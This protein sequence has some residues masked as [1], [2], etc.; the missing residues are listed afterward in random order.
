M[1]MPGYTRW[2]AD[3]EV[4]NGAQS[5]AGGLRG[6]QAAAITRN[7][8]TQFV[9]GAGGW[10]V[11]MADPPN[12]V[13][14]TGSFAEGSRNAVF[15]GVDAGGLPATTIV[16]NALGQ[17]PTN[18]ANL[19]QVDVSMP[20]VAGTRALRVLV[21]ATPS[22]VPFHGVKLCD[23]LFAFPDPKGCPP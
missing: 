8:N 17:V 11:Q 23:P 20:S 18:A 7:L 13:L 12:A 19:V 2:I 3:N 21:G 22:G 1:A 15:V 14:Q 9:L 10:S 5:I 4:R 16:F 6:A